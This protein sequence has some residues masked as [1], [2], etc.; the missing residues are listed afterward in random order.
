ML[1]GSQSWGLA[2]DEEM[3]C[4]PSPDEKVQADDLLVLQGSRRDLEILEGLHMLE[5]AEQSSS[6]VA[7]LESQQIGAT[8][9]LALA[10]NHP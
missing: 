3:L 2:R 5:I 9:V 1:S 4:M 7:E 6:L 8:E 10:K